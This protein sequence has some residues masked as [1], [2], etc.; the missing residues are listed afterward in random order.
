ML[1]SKETRASIKSHGYIFSPKLRTEN[2]EKVLESSSVGEAREKSR[3]WSSHHQMRIP[4][5]A[6]EHKVP[7]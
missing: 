3:E 7:L 4:D 1:Y 6:K 5:M 2:R